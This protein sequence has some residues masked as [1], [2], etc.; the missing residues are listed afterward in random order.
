MKRILIIGILIVLMHLLYGCGPDHGDRIDFTRGPVIVKHI[1]AY[2]GQMGGY[3]NNNCCTYSCVTYEIRPITGNKA[4]FYEGSFKDVCGKYNIGDT[5][6]TT[7]SK[8]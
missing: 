7:K 6:Y 3:N 2:S 8:Q 4:M 5:V 1:D